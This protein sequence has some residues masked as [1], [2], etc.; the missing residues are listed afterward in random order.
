MQDTN[1]API[2]KSLLSL[3]HPN[4]LSIENIAIELRI[5]SRFVLHMHRIIAHVPSV[6]IFRR[7]IHRG[8]ITDVGRT[9]KIELV[10]KGV[11]IVAVKVTGAPGMFEDADVGMNESYVAG[12]WS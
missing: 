2:T 5:Q 4:I 8:E 6:D 10:Q 7:R 12:T 9:R 1:I 3:R 11:G